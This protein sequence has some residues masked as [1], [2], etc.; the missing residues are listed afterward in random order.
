MID[1]NI[2]EITYFL[3]IS[4]HLKG[5]CGSTILG[6]RLQKPSLRPPMMILE[7]SGHYLTPVSSKAIWPIPALFSKDKTQIHCSMRHLATY[8]VVVSQIESNH[9]DKKTKIDRRI[10]FRKVRCLSFKMSL[11]SSKSGH[12]ARRSYASTVWAF[13]EK[14]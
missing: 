1:D 10:F 9:H 7:C 4:A 6:L 11:W 12:G 14:K 13:R 3:G 2:I 8:H 5:S